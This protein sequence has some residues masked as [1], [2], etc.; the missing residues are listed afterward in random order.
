MK[1]NWIE[2]K[3]KIETL[4]NEEVAYEKIGR[5]YGVT[6]ACIKKVATKL[7]IKL[8]Q[9]RSINPEETFNKKVKEKH[10]CLNCGKEFEHKTQTK[11]KFCSPECF[12]EYKHKHF[13]ENWKNGVKDGVN[14]EYGVSGAIRKY[15]FEK[16]NCRCQKCGWGEINE[17]TGKVPLQ[18]H[19]IDGDYRNNKEDNLQLLCPNCHSLTETYMSLNK[20]GRKSRKKYY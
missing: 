14:G 18:I 5:I 8:K 19:H 12:H 20:N 15:L 4:I 6:G 11:N 7:G 17:T 9:R 10:V 1:I 3:E 16:Y 13:I 2:E